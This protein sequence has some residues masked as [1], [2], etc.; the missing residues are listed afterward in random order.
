MSHIVTIELEIRD[1]AAVH[2]ACDRLGLKTPVEGTHELFSGKVQG[3]GV[4]LPQWKYPVVCNT[5]EGVLKYDNFGGR[6]GEQR[7]LDSFMQAYAVEK[8]IIEAR[9]KGYSCI[10][11]TQSDGSI[12]LIINAGGIA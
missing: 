1:P 11:Q 5:P 2:A 8:S 3:L 6:W 12:R 4:Q 7:H 10:E 9:R